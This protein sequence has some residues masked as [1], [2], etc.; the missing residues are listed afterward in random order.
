MQPS[1]TRSFFS[2][3]ITLSDDSTHPIIENPIPFY[4]IN[5]RCITNAV[6]YG[7]GTTM[8][9]YILVGEVAY[10]RN[11]QLND[12]F[13]KN[14]TAGSNGEIVITGTVPTEY[15]KDKLRY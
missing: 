14:K 15:I 5:L 9:D 8:D 12:I 7:D 3:K 10:F 13:I 11:G 2:H 6:N 4:D 1:T